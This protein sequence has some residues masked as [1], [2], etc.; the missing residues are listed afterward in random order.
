MKKTTVSDV[1]ERL[2]C[3]NAEGRQS[4]VALLVAVGD[5]HAAIAH[6]GHA[7]SSERSARRPASVVSCTGGGVRFFRARH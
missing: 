1:L 3:A 6:G 5:V 7:D 2:S 4:E